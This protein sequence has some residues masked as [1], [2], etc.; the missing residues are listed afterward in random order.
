M[1]VFSICLHDFSIAAAQHRV[2]WLTFLL[3]HQPSARKVALIFKTE[4]VAYVSLFHREEL[5]ILK[6][7]ELGS[8][9]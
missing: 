4:G 7:G 2:V 9:L 1:G 3:L 5:E 8:D 6:S